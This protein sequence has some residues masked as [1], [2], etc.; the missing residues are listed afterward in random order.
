M[1]NTDHL[2]WQIVEHVNSPQIHKKGS[3]TLFKEEQMA[4]RYSKKIF[5]VF[6]HKR[7]ANQNCTEIPSHSSQNGYHQE[8]K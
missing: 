2:K 8:S 1:R 5:K 3:Q 7:N 4:N 6:S